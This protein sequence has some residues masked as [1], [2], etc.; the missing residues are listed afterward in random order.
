MA[1]SIQQW[2]DEYGETH[3]NPTNKLI[4]WICIPL[5][6]WS[7]IGLLACIPHDYLQIAIVDWILPY[8]HWGSVII[9][10]GLLFYVRLSW[11]LFFGMAFFSSAVLLSIN[12]LM[13]I[14]TNA[15]LYTSIAV[16]VGA[17]IGQFIGHNIEGKK[18]SFFKDLQFLMIGPAWLMGFILK[19]TGIGY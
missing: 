12:A 3:Q 5:I 18:P 15:L 1:K 10:L 7:I 6:F 8:M 11:Q 14:G 4:H 16:F 17:W 9:V 13:T 19:R 2:F